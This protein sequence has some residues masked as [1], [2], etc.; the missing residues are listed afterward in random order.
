[1]LL[2][3][4]MLKERLG[5]PPGDTT[6]DATITLVAE[7]AQ[8]IA[9]AYC[10]RLF[11]L[12]DDVETFPGVV[13][14]F[15]VRRYPL[16]SI[17]AI[18]PG[19]ALDNPAQAGAALA[20]YRTDAAKGLVWTPLEAVQRLGGVLTCA[21]RGGYAA[22]PTGLLWALLRV[23]DIV[24]AATPGGGLEP[25]EVGGGVFDAVKRFS[26]VGAY[27]VELGSSSAEGS[28]PGG[29]GD[30]A[31]GILGPDETA[32]LDGYRRAAAIGVG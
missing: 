18:T 10:D 19:D 23:F 32:M 11:E 2:D 31:F 4:A 24:W 22:A 20:S 27:S 1:M 17:A 6:K 26:V 28:S 3:L 14:S 13:S 25:G 29:G 7:Q 12:A 21:Y 9:E 16:V 5:I 15:Q 8:A 30:N